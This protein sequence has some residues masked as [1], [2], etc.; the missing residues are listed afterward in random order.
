[1]K[2][3][4]AAAADISVNGIREKPYGKEPP[5]DIG[6]NYEIS[7]LRKVQRAFFKV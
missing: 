4:I 5:G 2:N 7:H 6:A 3:G 1:M